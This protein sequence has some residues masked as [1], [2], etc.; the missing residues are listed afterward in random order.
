MSARVD[1]VA[2]RVQSAIQMRNVTNSMAGVVKSMDSALKSMNLEKVRDIY[3]T[4]VCIVIIFAPNV[5]HSGCVNCRSSVQII[6][7]TNLPRTVKKKCIVFVFIYMCY[8][9][10]FTYNYFIQWLDIHSLVNLHSIMCT[11]L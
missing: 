7:C 5:S 8:I 11:L 2:S 10:M 4:R 3:P 1:G 6:N 9:I